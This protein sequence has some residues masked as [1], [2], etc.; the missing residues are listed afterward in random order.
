MFPDHVRGGDAAP[1]GGGIR[2][3]EKFERIPGPL[4][5][6]VLD[7]ERDAGRLPVILRAVSGA[8]GADAPA[9]PSM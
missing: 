7:A 5:K 2:C 8:P 3:S 4:L 6:A 9:F 1:V